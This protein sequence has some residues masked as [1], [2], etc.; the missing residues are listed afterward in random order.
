MRFALP[1]L[2]ALAS[3]AVATTVVKDPNGRAA[4]P[5]SPNPYIP[6]NKEHSLVKR[7]CFLGLCYGTSTPDYTSDEYNCGQKGKVCSTIW[8]NGWGAQ[9]SNGV[10]GPAYCY[11]LFDFNWLS[12]KCQDVSSDTSNW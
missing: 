7:T 5:T 12:G 11:N 9:C 10:C 1:S 6:E 3:V 2:F 8:T 4:N